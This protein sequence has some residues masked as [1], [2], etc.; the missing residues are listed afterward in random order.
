MQQAT[1][2]T[3]QVVRGNSPNQVEIAP[4]VKFRPFAAA[5][6]GAQNLTTGTVTFEPRAKLAYHRH[7]FSEA[8]TVIEGELTFDVEGRRYRL[9]AL[10]CIHVPAG[11]V[12]AAWN[13]AGNEECV[14]H[15][16]FAT[17]EPS[18]E[19]VDANFATMVRGLDNPK[20]NEP[21][22]ISRYFKTGKYPLA[23]GTRFRDLF[24]GR[25]GSKGIC[26]GYG[27]FE[28][29]TGLPCHIHKYDE[30]ITIVRGAAVCQVAG[31]EYIVS[32]LD[33]ALVPEGRPH[34]FFNDTNSVMSM[35]WVYAGDEPEREVLDQDYCSG[36]KCWNP[37]G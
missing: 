15:S 22:H 34:R 32:G 1:Q 4:H 6:I 5:A 17:S 25:F 31:N 10:D 2:R 14:C 13:S 30:S 24:A 26:G 20:P 33:T 12:H 36:G 9:S 35:I 27:E 19:L 28:P 8:I 29:G 37:N 23:E 16:A 21:E 18:R 11:T 3:E 7:S